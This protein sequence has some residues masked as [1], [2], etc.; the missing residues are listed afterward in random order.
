MSA[1]HQRGQLRL[2]IVSLEAG[3]GVVKL[4][5]TVQDAESPVGVSTLAPMLPRLWAS[6]EFQIDQQGTLVRGRVTSPHPAR[7]PRCPPRT[8]ATVFQV[9]SDLFPE[10]R[11]RE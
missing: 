11:E 1:L 8:Q 9:S 4:K 5:V 2:Q 10:D 6:R 3:G 7:A